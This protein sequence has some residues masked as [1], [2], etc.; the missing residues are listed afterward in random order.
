MS[1][2]VEGRKS[3]TANWKNKK[4]NPQ[5]EGEPGANPAKVTARNISSLLK[6]V[7][8][9]DKLG[10]LMKLA[11]RASVEFRPLR[12]ESGQD[13]AIVLKDPRD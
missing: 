5:T 1:G 10:I 12:R 11:D 7:K 3:I 8:V 9:E 13:A 6:L 2:D 4:Q